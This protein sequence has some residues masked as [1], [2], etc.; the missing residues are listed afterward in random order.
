[1]R[2]EFVLNE[3]KLEAERKIISAKG[4]REAQIIISEGLT[5]EIIKIKAIEAFKQLSN[6]NN[7]KVIITDGKTPLIIDEKGE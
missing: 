3:E 2:M 6:S 5:D 1:M 4:E 7:S